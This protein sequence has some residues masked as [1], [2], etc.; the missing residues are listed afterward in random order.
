MLSRDFEAKLLN[1]RFFELSEVTD[2]LDSDEKEPLQSNLVITDRVIS[3]F[4][5]FR[6]SVAGPANF[7][8]LYRKILL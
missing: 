6:N 5:P 7:C 4:L 3:E 8:G 1:S 2:Q